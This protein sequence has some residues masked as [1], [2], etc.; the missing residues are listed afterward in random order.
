MKTI[1]KLVVAAILLTA[2]VQAGRAAIK[3]YAFVDALQE[4]M[5]FVGSRT[6]EDHWSRVLEIA[7]DHE[8]PLE[9]EN[10]HRAPRPFPGAGGRH[11]T[12]RPSTSAAASGRGRGTSRLTWTCACSRTPVRVRGAPNAAAASRRSAARIAAPVAPRGMRIHPR[13]P[14]ARNIASDRLPG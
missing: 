7:G 10:A 14:S 6:E 9:Y 13:R 11:R 4:A 5:L 12:P 3:H 1:I 8:V 2:T